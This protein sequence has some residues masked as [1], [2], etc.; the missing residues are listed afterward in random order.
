MT[1]PTAWTTSEI[2]SKLCEVEDA[3]PC[4]TLDYERGW[5]HACRMMRRIIEEEPDKVYMVDNGFG[6]IEA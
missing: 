2:L 5:R 4:S 1:K 3:E 6:E